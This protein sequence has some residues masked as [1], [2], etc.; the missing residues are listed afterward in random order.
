MNNEEMSA[1]LWKTRL[2]KRRFLLDWYL[3]V[4]LN[5]T[6]TLNFNSAIPS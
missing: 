1:Q 5:T 2:H 6:C 4:Y 3:E